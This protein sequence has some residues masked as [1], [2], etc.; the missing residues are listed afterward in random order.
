MI[1][2]HKFAKKK[3]Y[4]MSVSKFCSYTSHTHTHIL[5]NTNTP[6]GTRM[7][8]PW[9]GLPQHQAFAFTIF[10]NTQ[11]LSNFIIFLTVSFL[12]LGPLL[13]SKD[14]KIFLGNNCI[15]PTDN[16]IFDLQT[17]KNGNSGSY[18]KKIF[19]RLSNYS[20]DRHPVSFII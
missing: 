3:N 8:W 5:L 10:L 14:N 15:R 6:R 17:R 13:T 20:G 11:V 1:Y 19:N 16:I 2:V 9:G 18:S 4:S 7:S 12:E